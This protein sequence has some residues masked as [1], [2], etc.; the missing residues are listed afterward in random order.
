[1][2]T[3]D[4]LTL[5]ADSPESHGRFDAATETRRQVYCTVRSVGMREAYEAMSHGLRP[6]WVFVLTHSFEYNGEK[7]CEF[8]G[9][10]YTV[11]RTYV[12]EADGIEITVERGNNAIVRNADSESESAE[13]T[14][15]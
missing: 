15:G 3:A 5:I 9:V 6:E 14:P 4:V 13:N 2:V 1:M 12:T 10:P 8:R 7:R 11:L